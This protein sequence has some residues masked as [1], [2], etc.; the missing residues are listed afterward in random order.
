MDDERRELSNASIYVRDN[1]IV[2]V[3]ASDDMPS[4][5]ADRV[6]DA[7][8]HVVIPGLVN[9]HHHMFQ[10]LTRVLAQEASLFDWL[11]TLYPIW[12]RMRTEDVKVATRTAMAELMLSGCTTTSD[13]LYLFP[14]DVRLDDS[15]EV[16]AEMGMRFHAT[17]GAMSLGES[18]G[19]L[20][21]DSLVEGEA[22]ILRDM[23]R[24]IE[25]FHDSARYAMLRIALA[26]CSPFSVT[27]DLMRSSAELARSHRVGLHTHLA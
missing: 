13:H 9:A 18:E 20:P 12:A 26:P 8:D 4:P 17:R 15:I 25:S 6:I 14:N 21:P 3:G 10:T 23:Q 1:V 19:G 5:R 11:K 27:P 16:A 2:A 22:S 7:R 24:V